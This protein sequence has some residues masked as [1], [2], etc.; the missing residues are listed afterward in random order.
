MSD[1]ANTIDWV[2]T[3]GKDVA[4]EDAS[5]GEAAAA[6]AAST[7]SWL[8]APRVTSPRD[9][10]RIRHPPHERDRDVDARVPA[11]STKTRAIT[12]HVERERDEDVDDAASIDGVEPA[13]A[14]AGQRPEQRADDEGDQHRDEADLEVDPAAVEQARPDVAPEVVGAEQVLRRRGLEDVE[15]S[16]STGSH[17]VRS[18]AKARR[19]RRA[20]R[21]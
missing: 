9:D 4:T 10:A 1:I 18:G 5:V 19:A 15:R 11:P 12:Q 13:T 14:V 21:G 6:R 3:F 8:L 16:C 17:E 2:I 7:Y 20:S